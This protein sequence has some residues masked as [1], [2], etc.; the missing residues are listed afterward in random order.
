MAQFQRL[1]ADW[2]ERLREW[3]RTDHYWAV[4]PRAI[5]GLVRIERA[6]TAERAYEQAFGWGSPRGA[7]EAKD[8]GARVKDG[9]V[10]EAEGWSAV[11]AEPAPPPPPRRTGPKVRWWAEGIHSGPRRRR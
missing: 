11:G 1:M 3:R 5:P 9:A 2:R 4:R 7:Y 10:D 8:L 6:E